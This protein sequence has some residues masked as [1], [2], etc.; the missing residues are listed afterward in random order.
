MAR[1]S[2]GHSGNPRGRP[3]HEHTFTEALRA[4]GT[5]EELAQLAWK[6]A[7]EGAPWAIQMIFNRLEPPSAQLTN[8]QESIHADS[9]DYS[10]LT[11]DEIQQLESLLERARNGVAQVESGKGPPAV[12]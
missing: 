7:R 3:K 10:R 6:A 2:K 5:P 12:V 4:H 1:W 11:T 8:P 9:T